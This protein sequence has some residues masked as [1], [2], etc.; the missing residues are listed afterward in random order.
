MASGRVRR[1]RVPAAICVAALALVL[2]VSGLSVAP[3]AAE[4]A[5]T[6][7][8]P[9]PSQGIGTPAPPVAPTISVADSPRARVTV[10]GTATPSAH[11]RVLDPVHPASSLCTSTATADGRW[12]CEVDL[13][14]GAGQTLTVRDLTD[15]ALGDVQ[16]APFSV[17]AAPVL[18]T[19]SGVDI[20][21]RVQ[22][23]GYPGARVTVTTDGKAAATATVSDAGQWSTVLSA[24]TTPSGRYSVQATQSSSRVPAVPVSSASAAVTVTIDR[25][26]P[27][28]P[29]VVHPAQG[30]TISRQPVVF[31]GT[32]ESGSTVTTYVDSN[33]VCTAVVKH[34][35]WSCSSEGLLLPSGDRRVQAA[36]RDA[37]GNYGAP[38]AAVLVTFAPS[39]PSATPSTPSA[40]PSAQP[41]TPSDSTEPSAAPPTGTPTSPGTP[42]GGSPSGGPSGSGGS[43]G[44]GGG[45]G[46]SGSGG[47]AGSSSGSPGS[48]SAST[49]GVIDSSSWSGPTGFGGTLPTLSQGLGGWSWMWA[50]VIGLVF[51]LLVVAPLRLAASALGGRLAGRAHRL[52]GRNRSLSDRDERSV[53]SPTAGVVLALA[54]GAVLVALAA[55]VDDQVR[56]IRLVVAIAVGIALINGLGVVLPTWLLG[57]RLGLRLSL[58]VSP[59][60][61]VGAV[62]ACV[63]TRVLG[64]DPPLAL[65]VLL[66]A[67]LADA[68]GRALEASTLDARGRDTGRDDVRRDD[69]RTGGVLATAQLGSLAGLSFLAWIAHGLMPASSAAF[70]AE[71][72]REALTTMC[73]AG[74]GSLIVLLVPLGALPGRA[75][76]AWSRPTLV[77]FAVIGVAMASVVYL[78]G[79]DETFP[80]LPLVIASAAFAT[81]AVGA[82]AWVRFV[83][84]GDDV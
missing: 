42:G 72:T 82:W 76:Y 78:G 57:R 9:T 74:L 20:G 4:A 10:S 22:G 1:G 62:A 83:E 60:L 63:A 73:L 48:G 18:S 81:L 26:A 80:M 59:R 79:P 38:S 14:S 53:L 68:G 70:A 56:Y 3:S 40:T 24:T 36:Q 49:P 45:T 52:A 2:I 84:P 51:L 15:T 54:V 67:G 23:T 8:T 31:D 11:L 37:A 46:G 55:G 5:P 35:V 69:V 13:V 30:S 32:G 12:S 34:G 44:S 28:A 7:A 29:T 71:I 41:T 47:G 16:S 6:S 27:A 39:S 61:L 66:A 21:A 77:G 50:L 19:G 17:L 33:P 65:G 43:T 25:D 75:L 58:S 64:I